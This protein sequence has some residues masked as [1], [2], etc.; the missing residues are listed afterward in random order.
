MQFKKEKHNEL[1]KDRFSSSGRT[2]FN[3]EY[4]AIKKQHVSLLIQLFLLS[5][6]WRC[7]ENTRFKS[8]K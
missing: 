3:G 8:T 5:L 4:G 7:H 2:V 1:P 6:T